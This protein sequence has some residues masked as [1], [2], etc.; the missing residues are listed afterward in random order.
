MRLP[1]QDGE[2]KNQIE[3]SFHIGGA[4][5]SNF[6]IRGNP[7]A[8]KST[9]AGVDFDPDDLCFGEALPKRQHFFPCGTSK[10]QDATSARRQLGGQIKELG[11]A[12]VPRVSSRLMEA[13]PMNDLSQKIGPPLGT[14]RQFDQIP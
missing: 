8:G 2:G 1:L 11:I 6:L 10:A 14:G 4:D 13:A 5:H 12:I 3:W 9:R 7:S